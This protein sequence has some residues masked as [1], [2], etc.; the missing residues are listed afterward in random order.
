[1]FPSRRATVT[2]R[3]CVN[4][5]MGAAESASNRL[6]PPPSGTGGGK[7][8][9]VG[10]E[11]CSRNPLELTVKKKIFC[12]SEESAITDVNNNLLFRVDKSVVFS[13]PQKLIFVDAAGLPTL[14]IQKKFW[15]ISGTWQMFKGEDM[16][17]E[18]HLICT[19]NRGFA[20]IRDKLNVYLAQNTTQEHC[21]FQIIGGFLDDSYAVYAGDD[22]SEIVAQIYKKF[23]MGSFLLG[24][25]E[26]KVTV[27]QNTDHAFIL[28]LVVILDA[29]NYSSSL[30]YRR[31]RT[32][33][34][35]VGHLD[36]WTASQ[37]I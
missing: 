29:L 19:V 24:E 14:T 10:P 4:C 2:Y 32:G 22:Q 5:C 16:T 35:W 18:E 8:V 7:L 28:A 37:G 9:V 17:D 26:Y 27:N 3:S 25:N 1:M 20:V 31:R 33:C 12:L 23:T 34:A 13:D 36:R 6:P 15:S 21:D 11:Y 30:Y